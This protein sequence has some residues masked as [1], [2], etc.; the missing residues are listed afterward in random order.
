MVAHV[1]FG[2]VPLL[3]VSAAGLSGATG[4]K[5]VLCAEPRCRERGLCLAERC[6]GHEADAGSLFTAAGLDAY[7]ALPPA[8][9]GVEGHN[10]V[11]SPGRQWCCPSYPHFY[12]VQRCPES[13]GRRRKQQFGW[14]QTRLWGRQVIVVTPCPQCRGEDKV[15]P[16]PAMQSQVSIPFL[17]MG[18]ASMV[19]RGTASYQS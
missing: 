12:F 11:H 8:C 7:P 4:V 5:Q 6:L 13:S 17:P 18:S 1:Q 9:K 3:G 15:Q 19:G 10:L 2:Q 16:L 14:G